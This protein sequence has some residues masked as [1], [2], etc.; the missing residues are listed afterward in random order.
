MSER[1]LMK[2]FLSPILLG[3]LVFAV[4]TVAEDKGVVHHPAPKDPVYLNSSLYDSLKI[5]LPIPPVLKS[6]SQSDDEKQLFDFQKS[7]TDA[8][9]MQA[10]AEVFVSLKGFFES[11]RGP[12]KRSDVEKLTPFFEQVRN[13]GDYFIQ[14][15][16][17]DFPRKRP[18]AYIEGIEPCVPKE[19]TGAYP[20]GHAA[21][22]KLYALILSDFFPAHRAKLEA[23]ALE[24]GKHRVLSGMHH[25]TDIASGRVLAE[26]LY[27]ELKKSKKFQSAFDALR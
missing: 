22:S 10:K 4:S 2:K 18:F 6:A 25:P 19:V 11:P 3:L 5:K 1:R 8:D 12:L 20:S 17:K 7:R 13:D 27:G 24:I 23:R 26:L 9:C 15:M 14:R 21:L 16:K